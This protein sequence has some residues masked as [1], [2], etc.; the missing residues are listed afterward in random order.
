M[1]PRQKTFAITCRVLLAAFEPIQRFII[2]T[3][4]ATSTRGVSSLSRG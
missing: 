2:S 1:Q 4:F 3:T